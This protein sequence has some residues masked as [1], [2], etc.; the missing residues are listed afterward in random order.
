VGVNP[1]TFGDTGI[2][3]PDGRM[4]KSSYTEIGNSFRQYNTAKKLVN[5]KIHW[6][7]YELFTMQAQG[8]GKEVLGFADF[9]QLRDYTV[10]GDESQGTE[11]DI[12]DSENAWGP[13]GAV[14]NTPQFVNQGVDKYD[15]ATGG[16]GTGNF[17]T[18]IG[19]FDWDSDGEG[20]FNRVC[21]V[22]E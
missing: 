15:I 14:Q 6:R 2:N 16:L 19:R 18:K 4:L 17:I 1:G 9:L 3:C 21:A 11:T 7:N 10:P 8:G 12:G 5:K 22:V 20:A 13:L